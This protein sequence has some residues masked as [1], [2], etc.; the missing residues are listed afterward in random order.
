MRARKRI[1]EFLEHRRKSIE[2]QK[3]DIREER[4]KEKFLQALNQ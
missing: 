2:R 3:S 4:G 1:E